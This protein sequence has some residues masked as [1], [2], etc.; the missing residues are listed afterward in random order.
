MPNLILKF[1][2]LFSTFIRSAQIRLRHLNEDKF[3]VS[4][5]HVIEKPHSYYKYE[6]FSTISTAEN[7]RTTKTTDPVQLQGNTQCGL[8]RMRRVPDET[9]A[10]YLLTKPQK[11]S[12]WSREIQIASIRRNTHEENSTVSLSSTLAFYAH[13]I[14]QR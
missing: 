3:F 12:I 8:L 1:I 14:L 6:P 7:R 2:Y 13:T 10:R 9:G 11:N 4:S 5:A